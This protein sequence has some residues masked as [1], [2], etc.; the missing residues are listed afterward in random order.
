MIH[1]THRRN[2]TQTLIFIPLHIYLYTYIP[3]SFFLISLCIRLLPSIFLVRIEHCYWIGEEI[4]FSV[5]IIFIVVDRH[6]C[7]SQP[8]IRNHSNRDVRMRGSK[9]YQTVQVITC[10]CRQDGQGMQ[11]ISKNN[12]FFMYNA[13][14]CFSFPRFSR[15]SL[16]LISHPFSVRKHFEKSKRRTEEQ[17]W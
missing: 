13:S 16:G 3:S 2:T 17:R 5:T 1:P 6:Y 4:L 14:L 10:G 9:T 15:L 11:G 7:H 12:A 8:T